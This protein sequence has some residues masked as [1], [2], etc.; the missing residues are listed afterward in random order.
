[1]LSIIIPA[2]NEVKRLPGCLENTIKYINENK[3]DSEILVVLDGCTDNTKSEA[4]KF[5]G[6]YPNI[7]IIEYSTN[8]GK[9]YAVK[10]GMLAAK[11]DY[12]LFMDAD[13]AV[14]IEF[15]SDFMKLIKSNDIVIGSR[16]HKETTIEKHQIFYRELAGILFGRF[17]KFILKIPFKDTQCGF[18]MY[19]ADAA[20]KLFSEMEFNCSYFDAE[21]IY[22]AFNSGMKIAEAPVSWTHDGETRMPI[23]IA[24]TIDLLKKLFKIKKIHRRNERA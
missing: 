14:P 11:G 9:G 6:A 1:M 13:Y 18:K 20:E 10:T 17:Q 7:K 15:I 8:K 12:R 19:T 3:I 22:N 5:R 23:G 16:G 24:R 2:Y 21:I 4:E